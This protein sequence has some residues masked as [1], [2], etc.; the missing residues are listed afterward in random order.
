MRKTYLIENHLRLKELYALLFDLD[1]RNNRDKRNQSLIV[2]SS[3]YPD[4]EKFYMEIED[5]MSDLEMNPAT[6]SKELAIYK[7]A[8][9]DRIIKLIKKILTQIE[10]FTLDGDQPNSE[11]NFKLSTVHLCKDMLKEIQSRIDLNS[12]TSTLTFVKNDYFKE[13]DIKDIF[14]ALTKS[15]CFGTHEA[16]ILQEFSK[17]TGLNME[18]LRKR[19]SQRKNEIIKTTDVGSVINKILN[20][21]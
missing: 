18:N 15:G 5:N 21:F 17:L 7:K 6:R 8:L 3:I 19:H 12:M 10:N 20:P 2:L 1:L 14:L 9:N 16:K 4:V 11:K 13:T